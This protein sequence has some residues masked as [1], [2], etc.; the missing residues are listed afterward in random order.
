[1]FKR[2]YVTLLPL[3]V[4]LAACSSKPKP[5]ETAFRWSFQSQ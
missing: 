4:L 1:M 5:T 2:R 3:F